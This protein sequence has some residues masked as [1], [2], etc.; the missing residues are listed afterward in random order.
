MKKRIPDEFT[1]AAMSAPKILALIF[2]IIATVATA[3]WA[4]YSD[5]RNYTDKCVSDLRQGIA[6]QV[7]TIRTDVRDTRSDVRE[8]K[9]MLI[10]IGSGTQ[11][12]I[13]Q[14]YWL[15]KKEGSE[16]IQAE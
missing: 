13:R 3:A 7:Q 4:M 11:P 6:D 16:K 5:A 2:T 1:T 12:N 15:L 9:N 14:E 10:L 8:I